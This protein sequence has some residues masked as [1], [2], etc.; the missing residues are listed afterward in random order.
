MWVSR[1]YASVGAFL[2]AAVLI[3]ALQCMFC[4]SCCE[5]CFRGLYMFIN[6]H[7]KSFPQIFFF[8]L[9]LEVFRVWYAAVTTHANQSHRSWRK[10]YNFLST[11][12]YKSAWEYNILKFHKLHIK[13]SVSVRLPIFI[14]QLI[15]REDELSHI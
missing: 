14:K 13:D 7:A 6:N 11:L 3:Y 4:F 1:R 12:Q 9:T 2:S 5:C 10:M 8:W 15:T